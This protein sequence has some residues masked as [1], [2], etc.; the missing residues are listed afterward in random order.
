[1]DSDILVNELKFYLWVYFP[2]KPQLGPVR[3][4]LHEKALAVEAW[5]PKFNN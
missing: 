2:N 3:C 5:H 4:I 1:M